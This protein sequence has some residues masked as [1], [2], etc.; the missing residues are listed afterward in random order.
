MLTDSSFLNR[1]HD[2]EADILSEFFSFY[3]PVILFTT[4][5]NGEIEAI[6]A[7][8]K[9]LSVRRSDFNRVVIFS[10]FKSALQ[11]LS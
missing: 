1:Y 7:V 9:Q 8:F 6:A 10:D 4:T 11:A 5:F 2:A 3:L